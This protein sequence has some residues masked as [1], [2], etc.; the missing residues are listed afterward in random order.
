MAEYV[1]TE[2]ERLRSAL[3]MMIEVNRLL[4]KAV[5]KKTTPR[6]GDPLTDAHAAVSDARAALKKRPKKKVVK[7]KKKVPVKRDVPWVPSSSHD[8]TS[9]NLL[10]SAN[11]ALKKSYSRPLS[12]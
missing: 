4:L 12:S 5:T 3:V 7:K 6:T 2:E 9:Y 11:C 8:G 1:D 10:A